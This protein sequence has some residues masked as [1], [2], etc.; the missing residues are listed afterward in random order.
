MG[1]LQ[2]FVALLQSEI[3][4]ALYRVQFHVSSNS[5]ETFTMIQRK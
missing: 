5:M 1:F 2:L 3:G 4:T